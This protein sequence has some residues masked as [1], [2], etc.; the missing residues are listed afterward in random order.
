[1][2]CEPKINTQW[3]SESLEVKLT[4]ESKSRLH[5]AMVAS[6]AVLYRLRRRKLHR[7]WMDFHKGV[8]K[9][10]ARKHYLSHRH[11]ILGHEPSED[12]P[13]TTSPERRKTRCCCI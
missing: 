5:A 1:M 10:Y 4:P 6:G 11:I 8:K 2:L 7:D 3:H 9:H 12:L 13:K